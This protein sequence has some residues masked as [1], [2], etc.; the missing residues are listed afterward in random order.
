MRKTAESKN[1]KDQIKKGKTSTIIY[2]VRG[3]QVMSAKISS[4]EQLLKGRL[5]CR[6]VP[7]RG[8]KGAAIQNMRGTGLTPPGKRQIRVCIIR[9]QHEGGH[10]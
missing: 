10:R 1:A 7:E 6:H 5:N 2:R 8:A 9:K 4:H 3:T